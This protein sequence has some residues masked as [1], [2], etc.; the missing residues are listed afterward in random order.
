MSYFS[1]DQAPDS[2]GVEPVY[3]KVA[4]GELVQIFPLNYN[5]TH[6]AALLGSPSEK[7]VTQYDNKV[8][9]PKRIEFTGILKASEVQVVKKLEKSLYT[10]NLKNM[11]CTFYGKSGEISS[12]M[13]IETFSEIGNNDTYDAVTVHV[14]LAEFLEHNMSS[15]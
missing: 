2:S 4:G 6:S 8:I 9:Q 7:G 12:N 3:I 11:K 13:L 15:N 10:H 14:K 5:A 1:A